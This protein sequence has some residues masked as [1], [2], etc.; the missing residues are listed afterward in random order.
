VFASI[1]ATSGRFNGRLTMSHNAG[2]DIP[3]ARAVAIGQTHIGSFTV[4]DL[5]FSAD[6][7]DI[8]F[9][10]DNTLEFA[11][12]NLFDADPPYSGA[13]PN[14]QAPGGFDN[15]GTLGRMFRLGLRTKF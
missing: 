8:K 1:G 9:L 14:A 5:F 11:V 4:A 3:P 2:V 10:K 13:Q 7:G 12:T 15:G 6:F